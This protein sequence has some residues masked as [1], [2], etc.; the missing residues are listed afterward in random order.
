MKATGH[1][2]QYMLYSIMH[3]LKKKITFSML[4]CNLPE[5]ISLSVHKQGITS[6]CVL[7]TVLI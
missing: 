3:I 2:L 1:I 5:D 6:I 7:E 4:V